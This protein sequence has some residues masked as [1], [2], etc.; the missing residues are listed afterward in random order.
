MEIDRGD[1]EN[2]VLEVVSRAL[3]EDMRNTGTAENDHAIAIEHN[4]PRFILM[5]CSF[6]Q[7]FC[8][9][10]SL[11]VSRTLLAYTLRIPWW[12]LIK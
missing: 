2:R 11:P 8:Q 7:L 1:V 5:T 12:R 4:C 10:F 6:F 9:D 3:K